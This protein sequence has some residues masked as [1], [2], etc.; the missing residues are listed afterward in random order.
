[1]VCSLG[2]CA[3]HGPLLLMWAAVHHLIETDSSDHAIKK[4]GHQAQQWKVF[5]YL[6]KLLETEPF[7]RKD[8]VSVDVTAGKRS[9]M[10]PRL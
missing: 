9:Y 1:M 7:D 8:S 4:L 2:D 5:H 10:Q 6:H 3:H